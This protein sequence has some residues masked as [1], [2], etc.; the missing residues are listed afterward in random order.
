LVQAEN[1]YTARVESSIFYFMALKNA[2]VPAEMHIYAEGGHGFGL[3]PTDAPVA[4]KW[5]RLAE[6]WLHTIHVLGS[7]GR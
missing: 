7:A 2:K 4:T 1:D 6:E 5:P 3:R